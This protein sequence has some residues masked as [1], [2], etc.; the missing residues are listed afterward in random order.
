MSDVLSDPVI[1][2]DADCS[3]LSV[4]HQ[5]VSNLLSRAIV[6]HENPVFVC[7]VFV[8]VF[9]VDARVCSICH[10]FVATD[11]HIRVSPVFSDRVFVLYLL[12]LMNTPVFVTNLFSPVYKP[13]FVL[14]LSVVYLYTCYSCIFSQ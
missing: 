10:V 11:V 4:S 6:K 2:C 14:Y 9:G 12:P 8:F 5:S 7:H 13:V 1:I 3:R